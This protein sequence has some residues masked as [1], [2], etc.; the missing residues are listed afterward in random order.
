MLHAVLLRDMPSM[1]DWRTGVC[2]EVNKHNNNNHKNNNNKNRNVCL[3]V[4]VWIV[5]DYILLYLCSV[6][7]LDNFVR[8]VHF[9]TGRPRMTNLEMP[10][11]MSLTVCDND[12]GY[13]D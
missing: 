2:R 8:L 13:T 5:K 3:H 11:G 12:D 10:R 6:G 4:F 9:R 7:Y 1:T